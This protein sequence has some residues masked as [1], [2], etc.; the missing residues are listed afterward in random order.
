[1]LGKLGINSRSVYE[2]DFEQPYLAESA[3][4]YALES[5]KQLVEM[6]AIDY[7][8]MAEQHF[9][10]ESQRE[11]L[12]LDPGTERLIQQAVYQELVASHV[13]A[14][15]AK[16]DSGVMAFLK[17]QRV[18]DLTRIFRLLSRAENG[19]KAVAER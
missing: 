18:E 12:Y 2:E 10:E 4:F 11:R 9:N 15:V 13:N 16:E 17:N 5:Q 6:S 14:I 3:K 19:R 8:D 1:M 7:I